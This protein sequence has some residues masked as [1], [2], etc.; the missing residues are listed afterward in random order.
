[1]IDFEA[2]ASFGTPP[3]E[4]CRL[5]GVGYDEAFDRIVRT[6]IDGRLR[7]GGSSEKFVVGPFGSGKTHFVRQLCELARERH[8]A[9]AEVKLTRDVDLTK[10]LIVY[11]QVVQEVRAP[12]RAERG[13]GTLLRACVGRVRA[14][15]G[16][17]GDQANELV[18]GWVN[19]LD[20]QDFESEAFVRVARIA[21][22][23]ILTGDDVRFEFARRWLGG[24][25]GDREVTKALGVGSIGQAEEGVFARRMLLS[26]FQLIRS[27]GFGGTVLAFDEAEQGMAVDQKT[28]NYI[29]SI[30]QSS[31]N[32]TV[33]LERGSAL[34]VYAIIPPIRERMDAFPALQQRLLSKPPFFDGNDYAP[35]IDLTRRDD[36]ERE[37]TLIG[38][39]LTALF[40]SQEGLPPGETEEALRRDL[41]DVAV[42]VALEDPSAQNRRTFVKAAST[43]LLRS[44]GFVP[45]VEDEPEV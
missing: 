8:C 25:I 33:D 16:D 27:A 12:D 4:G 1:M 32:A 34:I 10:P 22:D 17:D 3:R 2:L 11:R 29:F 21:F 13:I 19:G 28:L 31:I 40:L 30:M 35:I 6:F 37:L 7:R 24:E 38:G 36:A 20:Q 14:Q 18:A 5:F 26:L 23:S 43:R 15:A 45:P 42:A 9:T 39:K 41:R 44:R